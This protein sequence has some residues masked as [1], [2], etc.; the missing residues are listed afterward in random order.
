MHA[1]SKAFGIGLNWHLPYGMDNII[2]LSGLDWS[3]VL[4]PPAI[5]SPHHYASSSTWESLDHEVAKEKSKKETVPSLILRDTS[6]LLNTRVH[7]L[8]LHVMISLNFAQF[9]SNS[10]LWK[11]I[12]TWKNWELLRRI[13]NY[14][15]MFLWKQN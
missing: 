10:K 4:S 7:R 15:S 13:Y 8:Y 2:T 1:L 5:T 14:F 11:S 9:G 3:K 6:R 12:R